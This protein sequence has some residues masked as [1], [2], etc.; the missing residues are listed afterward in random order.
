[1]GDPI[2]DTPSLDDDEDG[3]GAG[4]ITTF[5]DL[6]SLLMCFFVLL[7]SFSEIEASKYKQVA[8][9]MKDAFGVQQDIQTK[10]IPKGTS[11]I[12]REFSPGKPQPTVTPVVQQTTQPTY[13]Q[14]LDISKNDVDNDD[15]ESQP[16]SEQPPISE[17]VI[18]IARLLASMLEDEIEDGQ[19]EIE[20][21]PDRVAIRV[22][23]RG[24]FDSGRAEIK[25]AFKPVLTRVANVLGDLS[26][27]VVV[28]GHTDDVPIATTRFPSNWELSAARASA[29][30]HFMTSGSRLASH[31][32]EIRAHG[33]M[34]PLS[35]NDSIENR[36][37]NRRV[38]IALV[39]P[40]TTIPD[41]R[42]RMGDLV[43][44]RG[45]SPQVRASE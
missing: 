26:G 27:P 44:A 19:I 3:G 37:R 2:E 10:D 39:V 25:A 40:T 31:R 33:E 24:S 8:G 43:A 9:S 17:D 1:M 7:L 6:M 5:A 45:V 15:D 41:V 21:M 14:H 36:A 13:H 42:K 32:L 38:E 30:V 35:P 23:E 12:S 18:E 20:A 11:I 28:S 22:K 4:W 29:F 34:K 16:A